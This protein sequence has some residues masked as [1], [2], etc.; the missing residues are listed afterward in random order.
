MLK[1]LDQ[2]LVRP[3]SLKST[4]S[5]IP[6]SPKTPKKQALA[7]FFGG[8][9][10]VIAFTVIEEKYGTMSGLIAGLV[11]GFGEIVYE[12]YKYKKVATITWVGN[13][14]L[15][16]MGAV[17][18][19]T[20]D[21]LW[22]KLQ[23]AIFEFGFFIFLCGSSILKK[24]FLKL[25]IE[26]Q[27]PEAPQ[28]LK[29]AMTGLTFRLGLFFLVHAI[30]ATYAALYWSTEAWAILKGIGLTVTMI[31]YMIFEVIVIRLRLKSPTGK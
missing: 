28:F 27:N 14:L 11:F 16:V 17:S 30:L 26:K 6:E 5:N 7:L 25:M 20:Q 24:P 23:P 29:E 1:Y 21:G 19:V 15:F 31:V 22:F 10:P 12:L 3:L 4:N 2:A 9:L 13:G 8:L 18:L